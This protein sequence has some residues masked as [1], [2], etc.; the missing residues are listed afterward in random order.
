MKLAEAYASLENRGAVPEARYL[1]AT[2]GSKG[3]VIGQPAIK[4]QRRVMSPSIALAVLHDL[5]GPVKSGTARAANS[6]HAMVYGKT[7][8]SSRNEDALFVGLTEDFVGSLWL[9]YDQPTPMPGVHGGGTP[10]NAFSKL[11]DFYYLRLAQSRLHG[12]PTEAV[13]YWAHFDFRHL[14]LRNQRLIS[15]VA[16][17]SALLSCLLLSRRRQG[18]LKVHSRQASEGNSDPQQQPSPQPHAIHPSAQDDLV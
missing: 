14:A 18:H 11:T 13:G 5:R 1:I 15:L 10:A 12:D 7:G 3:N 17:G 16:F 9:G 2:I 4:S 6:L 8:T